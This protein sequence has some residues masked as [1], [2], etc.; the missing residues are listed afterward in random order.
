MN[1]PTHDLGAQAAADLLAGELGGT[2]ARWLTWLA[3]DRRPGRAGLLPPLDGP[4]RPRYLLVAL[5]AYVAAERA[6]RARRD[7][8]GG[9]AAEVMRAFGI[10]EE[11][12]SR[13]G[14][15]L[16]SVVTAQLDEQNGVGFVQLMVTSPLMV[17]RLNIDEA[18]ALAAQLTEMTADAEH[19]QRIV[20]QGAGA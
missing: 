3:N 1:D 14:R 9:R 10:G 15:R 6:R 2:P 12:G 19:L 5:E 11:G 17:F 7:G 8:I 18:R 4:G 20:K 13:T 16:E